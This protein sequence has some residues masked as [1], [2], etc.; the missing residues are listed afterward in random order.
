M[1]KILV[2]CLIA[3]SFIVHA[4]EREDSVQHQYDQ[5]AEQ[6]AQLYY[7]Q[8]VASIEAYY[9]HFNQDLSGLKVLDLGCGDGHDLWVLSQRGAKIYGIDASREMVELSQSKNPRAQIELAT[10][11]ELPFDDESFDLVVSKWALQTAPDILPAYQ[12][13]YRVLKPGGQFIFLTGHPTRQF[14]EKKKHPKNYFIKETVESVLFQGKLV[15][16]EPSHTMMEYMSPYFLSHF[17]LQSFEEGTDDGAEQV[18]GDTYPVYALFR[19]TKK[20]TLT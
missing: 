16:Q 18:M 6:Y 9:K 17:S 13:A 12:E 2:A 14:L 19:A 20:S 1:K 4:L 3:G 5:F 11:D 7:N 8:N 15:V 10:F